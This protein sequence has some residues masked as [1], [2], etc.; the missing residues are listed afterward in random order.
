MPKEKFKRFKQLL[1]TPVDTVELTEAMFTKLN[2]VFIAEDAHR[3]YEFNNDELVD[4]FEEFYSPLEY[5]SNKLSEIVKTSINAVWVVDLPKVQ[6]TEYPAPYGYIV[7]IS[8]VKDIKNN[9]DNTCE[10]LLFCSGDSLM[11]Y[12]DESIRKFNFN[13]G[14]IG[15]LEAE[16]RH[17]LG[18]TPARQIWSEKLKVGD[19]INKRSPITNVLTALDNWLFMSTNKK[20]MDL[21]NSYPIT[22]SYKIGVDIPGEDKQNGR[23]DNVKSP[24]GADLIGPGSHVQV[25]VPELGRG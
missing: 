13:D 3:E 21:G 16:F 14:N 7:D 20:Y 17:G 2:R 9:D 12:D 11:V 6:I 23:S 8:S 5:M 19:N 22:A 24:S 18:Y 4:D 10:W 25:P 15:A 1:T